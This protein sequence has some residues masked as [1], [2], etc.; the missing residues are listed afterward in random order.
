MSNQR[1]CS[2]SRNFVLCAVF[3]L[4]ACPAATAQLRLQKNQE[5]STIQV[6]LEGSE[7]AIVTQHA[8]P[9]FRPYIHPIVAPDGKGILT[10]YSPGHHKHQTGLYWGFTRV[11]GRD[12][13]HNP[14]KDYW[15]RRELK[16][17]KAEGPQASWQTVYDLLDVK[18]KTILTET[19]TWTVEEKQGE[20]IMDLVWQGKA[21][22][23]V[24]VSEY[25]YG[26]L[27]LR[28]P[29]K[30]GINA[31]AENS[32]RLRNQEAEGKR[33]VWVNAGMQVQGR[34]DLAH[35]TIFDHPKNK[36]YPQPW[37]VDK[38]LGIGP[39]R[40]RL[41]NWHISA[42]QTE[43]IRHRLLVHTGELDSKE[44]TE[45]WKA[46]TG[47]R[48]TSVL[49]RIAQ[50][51][52]KKAQML[53]PNEAIQ[54]MTA[55]E[56]FSVNMYA[57]EPTITQPMAFCWDDRG[58]LWV[59]ENRDYEAR[60]SGFSNSGDSRI[61]ILE[62]TDRDGKADKTT[63]FAD[64]IP[65]PAG[66]AVGMGGVWL[67]APPNLLFIPDRNE[68][69]KADLDDIEI[70]LTGWGIR[71]RH[72]TLN[73]FHW[74]PDGWL[75]GC[76][77]FATTSHVGKPRGKGKL[78]KAGDAFPKKMA[79]DGEPVEINGG[80]WR[81]HPIKDR[82]EVVAHGF[83]NPWGI[84]YDA[85]GNFFITACVIPHMFHVIPGGIYH[86]QGGKHFNPYVYSDIR[87]IVD[88]R[89]R[90][91]H[92]GARIYLSDAFPA[93]HHGRIFMCNIHERAVLSDILHRNG[94]GFIASDGDDFVKANDPQWVGFSMELGPDGA[95]YA[96]DWH[97]ADICGKQV[98]HKETGRIFRIAPTESQA[99]NW[100]DRFSDLSKLA[101][102]RLVELQTSVSSWHARRARI[103]LQHRAQKGQLTQQAL[104]RLRD[105]Y[106][107]HPNPDV[108]L[109]AMWTRH[110]ITDFQEQELIAALKD[111]DEH[112]R[113]W[114]IQMLNEDR[115][116]SQIV[117]DRLIA[118]AKNDPSAVVR[119]YLAASLQ[120]VPDTIKWSIAQGLVGRNV[121]QKDHNIPKMIW[122]GICDLVPNEIQKSLELAS[123]SQIPL[124]TEFIARRIAE[125]NQL[126]GLTETLGKSLPADKKITLLQ[127]IR[128]GLEGKRSLKAP[129]DW[130]EMSQ[131]ISKADTDLAVR[132]A[133]VSQ[134]FGI[135]SATESQIKLASDI[136]APVQQRANAIR[137][138]ALQQN[139]SLLARLPKLIDDPQVQ[140]EA[141]RAVSHYD[142]I[143]LSKLLLNRYSKLT[144][145]AQLE[146]VQALATRPKSGW[147]LTQ[148][149]KS[150]Q[151]PRRAVPAYVARQ[152]RRVVGNGFVEI[153]GPIDEIG[154][155]KKA[156][157]QKY[158]KLL[159]PEALSK[160][161]YKNGQKLYQS[162]CMAC[163]KLHGQ[164]GELGPDITGANRSNLTYLLDNIL[165]PS[166][167]IQDDYKMVVIT[168]R[169]GRT[170]V[171]NVVSENER[172]L[173][174]RIV[175]QN[176]VL[177]L[178]E[179]QSRE[180]SPNSMM[181]EGL[182]ENLSDKQ[183]ID[184]FNYLQTMDKKE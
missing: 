110:I 57:S 69:D 89:H 184:L 94:S 76:Q 100:P 146:A 84:D 166:G 50:R 145:P 39:V 138:L 159:T 128:K 178:S 63:V 117:Y 111:R 33:D 31:Q 81:Y 142:Q 183:V 158:R 66:M 168:T 122:F 75:Y 127:G 29:W 10:E 182:L 19:Q 177:N 74:G 62:D 103:V 35:I 157:Y 169:D 115:K 179:I 173:T 133:E 148:A 20:Y 104:D 124:V 18:G 61:L 151:V 79:F 41:G 180:V 17:L 51:E 46:W 112:I 170:F 13:F 181:P 48:N 58:R 149:I 156:A 28:M 114:A 67:G 30:K 174:L 107:Q 6:F 68:D 123:K 113:A 92:G 109:R 96:L 82:F 99:K 120:R 162:A 97:D 43:T 154:A 47:K 141:I 118:L 22:Q 2:L 91:A 55:H 85:K 60:H 164:G 140:I 95:L 52:A 23:N 49:W 73:S 137:S 16:I 147:Q 153:W 42:G 36:G 45:K 80:V 56:G 165:D 171:G 14:G 77:G 87:T 102:E 37:R 54:A 119:L 125:D 176:I 7:R 130:E 132:V 163:H 40:A 11:N 116:A 126:D 21:N 88:H 44:V 167:I 105:I 155:D 5:N 101:D 4:F 65:F 175:G 12:F 9:G 25:K 64:G 1:L 135:A 160:G 143:S 15:Q 83:S 136:N 108:R 161:N 144:P 172:Q 152:L 59:A 106:K 78:Y 70:R 129:K 121:D 71:D 90:S 150:G 93:K 27:F 8:R 86:R 34:K 98:L 53:S 134:L 26:G 72:E 32:S 139:A 131:Q 38:Q 24:K 3:L